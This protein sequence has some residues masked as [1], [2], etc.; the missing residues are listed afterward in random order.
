MV[1]IL[2]IAVF[3]WETDKLSKKF[4]P[5]SQI[6]KIFPKKILKVIRQ[7]LSEKNTKKIDRVRYEINWQDNFLRG[8]D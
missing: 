8:M 6:C 4:C 2:T 1:F 5:R 3:R 7:K